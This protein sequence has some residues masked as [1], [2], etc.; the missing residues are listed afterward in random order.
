MPRKRAL[1]ATTVQI[2]IAVQDGHRFGLDMMEATG[3]PSGTVYPTLARLE[4][5]AYLE[6]EWEDEA[7]ARDA[8][9]PRRRYYRVTAEGALAL[10][11][12]LDRLGMIAGAARQAASRP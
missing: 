1:G 3:L 7:S 11:E 10:R 5:R 12:A 2:L 6:S 8:C 9:R 4:A